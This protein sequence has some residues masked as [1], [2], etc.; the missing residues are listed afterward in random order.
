M[1]DLTGVN[2]NVLDPTMLPDGDLSPEFIA[3]LSHETLAET[4]DVWSR[5][6]C[7]YQLGPVID[8][9]AHPDRARLLNGGFTVDQGSAQLALSGPVSAGFMQLISAACL[10]LLE[11]TGAPNYVEQE[12]ITPEPTTV[13]F[14]ELE[15]VG[16]DGTRWLVTV[17]RKRGV[18]PGS[19]VAKLR[20]ALIAWDDATQAV[21]TD[22]LGP[23]AAAEQTLQ[24][25]VAEARARQA[26]A[27]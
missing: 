17:Q 20:A 5:V 16:T 14:N 25:L 24:D 23:L 18:S 7:L 2:D 9:M 15:T 11:E 12:V 19:Q 27:E 1:S 8:F 22:G 13:A 26:A 6:L 21:E 10:G 4:L 3:T